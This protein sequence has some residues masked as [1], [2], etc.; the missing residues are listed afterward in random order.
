[1]VDVGLA[2]PDIQLGRT[3]CFHVMVPFVFFEAAQAVIMLELVIDVYIIVK[4]PG[5][6]KTVKTWIYLLAALIAP[7]IVGIIFSIWGFTYLDDEEI[8]FCNP[9]SCKVQ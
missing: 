6:Y 5:F 9:T 7:S 2:I 4:M 8:Y 1:M 3:S